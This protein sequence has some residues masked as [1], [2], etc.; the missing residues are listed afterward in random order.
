VI[1][2]N[3]T[4]ALSWKYPWIFAGR[5]ETPSVVSQVR[6]ILD[7]WAFIEEAHER[8]SAEEEERVKAKAH[9]YGNARFA[10]F[11]RHTDIQHIQAARF[12]IEDLNY[13]SR[14][15]GRDLDSHVPVLNAYLRMYQGFEPVRRFW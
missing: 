4:W 9:P 12:L 14:F 3:Q 10:G 7:M 8:F 11:D 5:T 1:D 2:G 13:F 6:N 15:K